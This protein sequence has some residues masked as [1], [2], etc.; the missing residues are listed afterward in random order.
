MVVGAVL[1]SL[2]VAAAPAAVAASADRQLAETGVLQLSDFPAG[3]TESARGSTSDAVVDREAAALPNCK[4][5]TKFAAANKKCEA[6]L[7]TRNAS[8]T[9]VPS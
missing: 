3:W 6:L 5:F 7:P 1:A 9:T 2:V 4:A 8:T